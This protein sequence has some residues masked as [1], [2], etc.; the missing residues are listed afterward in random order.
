VAILDVN[1]E[2]ARDAAASLGTGYARYAVN[3][4][5]KSDCWKAVES[6]LVT[7]GRIDVPVVLTALRTK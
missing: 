3:V 5:S 1:G 6:I 2:G 4:T 7:L